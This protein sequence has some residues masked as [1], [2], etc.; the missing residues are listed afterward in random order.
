MLNYVNKAQ[1]N[2]LQGERVMTKE[3]LMTALSM[4]YNYVAHEIHK[5]IA[6]DPDY[7]LYV[8]VKGEH[9]DRGVIR[10]KASNFYDN[11]WLNRGE[12]VSQVWL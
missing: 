9:G 6:L 12:Y 4:Q 10:V 7:L 3:Q 11:S 5:I 1:Q 2:T 8:K